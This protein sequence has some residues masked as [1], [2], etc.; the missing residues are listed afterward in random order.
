MHTAK[1]KYY[2]HKSVFKDKLSDYFRGSGYNKFLIYRKLQS[3]E[4]KYL[5]EIKS[6]NTGT[7]YYNAFKGFT[8]PNGLK[9][10]M[11]LNEAKKLYD[12]L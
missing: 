11:N 2:K 4:I 6:I 5:Y 1:N 12:N 7:V 3:D 8:Y 10:I 9:P